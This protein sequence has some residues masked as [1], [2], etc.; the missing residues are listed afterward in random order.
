MPPKEYAE[1]LRLAWAENLLC[2]GILTIKEIAAEVN[3]HSSSHVSA[4]FKQVY[5]L[6]PL[7]VGY[8][9]PR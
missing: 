7:Q 1:R 4:A 5:S 3:Y 8:Y 6:A 9:L 2:E